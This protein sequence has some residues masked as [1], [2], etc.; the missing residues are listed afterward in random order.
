FSITAS[1]RIIHR[2]ISQGPVPWPAP[3]DQAHRP[4]TRGAEQRLALLDNSSAPMVTGRSLAP[5]E[6]RI[7][8]FRPVPAWKFQPTPWSNPRCGLSTTRR[9]GVQKQCD[10]IADSM[11]STVAS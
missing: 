11:D 2:Y 1:I 8:G 9:Q 7:V 4:R 3:N 10:S 5:N 6:Y